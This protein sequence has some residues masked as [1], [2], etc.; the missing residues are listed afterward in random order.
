MLQLFEDWLIEMA[1][2]E[3]YMLLEKLPDYL[4][5]HLSRVRDVDA[6]RKR[7]LAYFRNNAPRGVFSR[8]ILETI[9]ETQIT[10]TH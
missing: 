3:S 2:N 5:G 8:M 4:N 6:E 1:K 7:L 10:E 9:T